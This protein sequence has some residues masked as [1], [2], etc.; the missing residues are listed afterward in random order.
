[1]FNFAYAQPDIAKFRGT[2]WGLINA[3]SDMVYHGDPL[4][5]TK[6]YNANRWE[7]S[8]SGNAILDK[9]TTILGV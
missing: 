6:N 7:K 9:A 4:R 8:I 3:V 5:K 2:G 1:L